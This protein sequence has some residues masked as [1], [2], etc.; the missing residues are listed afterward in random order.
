MFGIYW[1]AR[2]VSKTVFRL[3]LTVFLL[4]NKL[5]VLIFSDFFC[6]GLSKSCG[7]INTEITIER[8]TTHGETKTRLY[9]IWRGIKRRCYEPQNISYKYYGGKGIRMCD[10]WRNSYEM[11]RDW[12][13]LNGYDDS[14][15]IDR[16]DNSKGYYPENCRW[17]TYLQQENNR[18][19]NHKVVYNEV[20]L[21]V[22]EWCRI[23]GI[24][25]TTLLRYISKYGDKKAV[26]IALTKYTAKRVEEQC[27]IR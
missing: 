12:A 21:N 8:S 20:T 4:N 25:K 14:L 6:H 22:S 15:T 5:C 18:A 17:A 2:V 7:C 10:E 19:S 26:E 23:T 13:I 24:P 3:N 27:V 11:F 1:R 9:S 16:I